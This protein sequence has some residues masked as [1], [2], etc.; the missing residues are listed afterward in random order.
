M[1]AVTMP[2]SSGPTVGGD[3][4]GAVD[5]TLIPLT[6]L[7]QAPTEQ[8]METTAEPGEQS[9]QA[10]RVEDARTQAGSTHTLQCPGGD[11][12]QPG[13]PRGRSLR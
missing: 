7:V 8:I 3:G 1:Q 2:A 11:R 9:G 10:S 5:E 6:Q 4:S 12:A 13:G